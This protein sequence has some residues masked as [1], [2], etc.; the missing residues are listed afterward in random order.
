MTYISSVAYDN[1]GNLF[2]DGLY[3]N[4]YFRMAELPKGSSAFT[5]LSLNARVFAGAI[6]WDA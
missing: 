5:T 1:A 2:V 3:G 6:Q 4:G